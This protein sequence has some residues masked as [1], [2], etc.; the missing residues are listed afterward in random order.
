MQIIDFLNKHGIMWEP[1]D[2]TLQQRADGKT[3]KKYGTFETS[4]LYQKYGLSATTTDFTKFS[5]DVIKK[6]QAL[7][8]MTD[9]IA[10]D[11]NIVNQIDIDEEVPDAFEALLYNA[12]HYK[13]ITKGLPHIFVNINDFEKNKTKHI[14]DGD[15]TLEFMC[16]Q[17]CLA[18]K[19]AVIENADKDIMLLSNDFVKRLNYDKPNTRNENKTSTTNEMY[20]E[21]I[22]DIIKNDKN[23]IDYNEWMKIGAVMKTRLDMSV[24]DFLQ[25]TNDP[26]NEE[27]TKQHWERFT[28]KGV[29]PEYLWK[30][31]KNEKTGNLDKFIQWKKKWNKTITP[32]IL[33]RGSNDICIFMTPLLFIK[34]RFCENTWWYCNRVNIWEQ[35]FDPTAIIVSAIQSEIDDLA[36]NNNKRLLAVRIA[37]DK[38]AIAAC[39]KLEKD[40]T[41]WRVSVSSCSQAAMYK[42]LLKKYLEDKDF[43]NKLNCTIDKIVFNNGIYDLMDEKFISGFNAHDYISETLNFEY[44]VAEKDDIIYVKE[45]I[46]KI[47]NYNDEHCEYFLSKLGA[48]FTARSSE[49]QE[50]Y[51]CTGQKACN[52]KSSI[53]EALTSIAPLYVGKMSSSA[54]EANNTKVHKDIAKWRGKRLM[55]IDEL[56]PK[57]QNTDLLKII[58]NGMTISYEVMY[59][60]T[61]LMQVLF[62]LFIVGNNS[63][64]LDIDSGFE[65]R[66]KHMQF[67][68]VFKF[69]CKKDNYEQ[70]IFIANPNFVDDLIAKYKY[71]LLQLIF[72][73]SK[74][75][76]DKVKF[77]YPADWE[78][79]KQ[80]ILSQADPFEVW[81]NNHYILDDKG[82]VS[83]YVFDKDVNREFKNMNVRDYFKR[84][85]YKIKT[86]NNH[87]W[88]GFAPKPLQLISETQNINDSGIETDSD[89]KDTDSIY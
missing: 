80:E 29:S 57:K 8:H 46:K 85:G 53:F 64:K 86:H 1:V 70:K 41:K 60:T 3:E 83:K 44:Q 13:S 82:I 72:S 36:A 67:D 17:W 58:A 27:K 50:F 43:I 59:G 39:E 71:A 20:H 68:S 61:A 40:I 33:A 23:C 34:L 22:F 15:K 74:K 25:F 2:I 4:A 21:L 76:Y 65:R 30:L 26:I 32:D 51:N 11:T 24:D 77:Q 87:Y 38:D 5:P 81:F 54:L 48:V 31:A 19:D 56:S 37:D 16:G 88:L 75:Y 89:T 9:F 6:R 45:Q 47:C 66:L 55:W 79:E 42:N 73:Y 49:M 10:I 35:L 18:H 84:K 7:L 62:G 14:I 12:P 63:I 78:E 69:D 28:D 52:G